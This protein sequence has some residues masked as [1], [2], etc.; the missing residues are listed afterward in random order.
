MRRRA[1]RHRGKLRIQS[2]RAAWS[3]TSDNPGNVVGSVL[4]R[5][6]SKTGEI[7][8]VG[9][10]QWALAEWMQNPQRFRNKSIA[11]A[12]DEPENGEGG[13]EPTLTIE[14]TPTLKIVQ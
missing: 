10:G 6:A 2:E 13:S 11:T 12:K 8:R 7:V 3:L 1:V 14:Q 9:R 5:H 4:S